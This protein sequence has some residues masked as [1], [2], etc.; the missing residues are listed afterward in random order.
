MNTIKACISAVRLAYTLIVRN[1]YAVQQT[2]YMF[3]E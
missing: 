1:D 3:C 2:A